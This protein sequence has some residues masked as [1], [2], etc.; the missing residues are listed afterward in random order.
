LGKRRKIGARMVKQVD[1]WTERKMEISKNGFQ[2]KERRENEESKNK[3]KKMVVI[4]LKMLNK[5]GEK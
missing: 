4:K 5:K 2:D 3:D 1:I